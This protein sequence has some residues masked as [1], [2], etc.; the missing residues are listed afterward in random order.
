MC[1][2]SRDI[3]RYSWFCRKRPPYLQKECYRKPSGTMKLDAFL[4][5]HPAMFISLSLSRHF[6]WFFFIQWLPESPTLLAFSSR[7]Y[8]GRRGVR[9]FGKV[10]LESSRFGSK[11][12]LV[13]KIALGCCVLL[14]LLGTT[15]SCLDTSRTGTHNHILSAGCWK[16]MGRNAGTGWSGDIWRVVV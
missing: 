12:T 1:R 7:S 11:H 9:N 14:C 15:M 13:C 6:S 10:A 8:L 16:H 3:V 2:V 4:E 5:L